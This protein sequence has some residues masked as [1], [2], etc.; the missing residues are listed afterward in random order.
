MME[1]MEGMDEAQAWHNDVMEEP[2]QTV[3]SPWM[4]GLP[5]LVP[6]FHYYYCYLLRVSQP[7]RGTLAF[8]LG[9]G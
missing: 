4:A 8:R 2:K 3:M 6:T 5:A 7:F 9:H 1:G